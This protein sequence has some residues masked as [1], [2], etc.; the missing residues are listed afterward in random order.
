MRLRKLNAKEMIDD[1][2]AVAGSGKPDPAQRPFLVR[3]TELKGKVEVTSRRVAKWLHDHQTRLHGSTLHSI[4]RRTGK[5]ESVL[6]MQ[7]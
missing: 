1:E 7:S 2:E 4:S 6:E 5:Q 3:A